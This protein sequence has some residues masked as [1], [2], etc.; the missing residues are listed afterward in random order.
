M[1]YMKKSILFLC[2]LVA[3][4]SVFAQYVPIAVTGFN[5]DVIAD[6]N[7]TSSLTTTTME[8]DAATVSNHVMCTQQ[9]AVANGFP[10][11]YG[12]PN[13]L[14]FVSGTSSY[15]VPVTGN[16]ALYL[17]TSQTGTLTLTTPAMY[18]SISLLVT[19]TEGTTSLSMTANFTDGTNTVLT[20]TVQDWYSGAGTIIN[21]G[22]GRIQRKNGPFAATDYDNNSGTAP[23]LFTVNFNMPCGKVLSSLLFKNTT[24]TVVTGS[25]RGFVF[26]VSG[27]AGSPLVTPIVTSTPVCSSGGTSTLTVTNPQVG[28]TYS[29]Y[30]VAFGGVPVFTGTAYTTGA[31][32]TNTTF[33]IV[34]SSGTCT[35]ARLPV[36][37]TLSS[38][39]AAPAA[40]VN[41]V[42][43]G[44]TAT[45]TI[46]SP[47]TGTTYNLYTAAT[48]GSPIATS[49][50]GTLTTPVIAAA[51]TYYVEAITSGGCPS[52]RTPVAV[53]L[54]TPFVNPVVTP[55]NIGTNTLTFSWTAVPGA[56]GYEVSINGGAYG[57]PSTGATGLSHTI[58][59][60][61]PN[62]TINITV[63][64]IVANACQVSSGSATAITVTDQVFV[65][66]VFTPNGDG[67]NDVLLVFSNI[68]QSL[69]FQVFNQ[70]GEKVFET[71]D[72][73][74]G[75]TGT[76]K[77]KPQPSGVYV[78]TL[79]LVTTAGLVIDRKGSVTL[80]R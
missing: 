49:T 36:A 47:V 54:L 42:C 72:K 18:S 80:V 69:H 16:N 64:T 34:A 39:P 9:F 4:S 66:N 61:T 10:T 67:K 27:I 32:S 30:T 17:L 60:L 78:Y 21:Q 48:G 57:P 3:G 26:A 76:Y 29:W 65:P 71:D 6:G 1:A 77:G 22:T 44:S 37:V 28:L 11:G 2:L 12:L 19:S 8:M 79:K 70:W 74:I 5:H 62:T 56:T 33:Y 25:T 13:S 75:W 41:N 59:G 63:R 46:A 20:T 24:S 55:T 38:P 31:I 53:G 14:N 58:N 52:I 40:T 43:P 45:V 7:G 35:T 73:S 51:I 23:R 15:Q 68:T 50:T